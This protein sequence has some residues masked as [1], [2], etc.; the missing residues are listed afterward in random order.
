MN[1]MVSNESYKHMIVA[2]I[3]LVKV[4]QSKPVPLRHAG[5]K[6]KRS[7]APTHS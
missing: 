7:I 2:D 5:A 6:G 4:K 1:G 3:T